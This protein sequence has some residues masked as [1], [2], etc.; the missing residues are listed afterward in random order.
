MLQVLPD[1]TNTTRVMLD[2]AVSIDRVRNYSFFTQPDSSSWRTID[3]SSSFSILRS[4][5]PLSILSSI[6]ES[7]R[8]SPARVAAPL[9]SDENFAEEVRLNLQQREV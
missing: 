1:S 5:L 8:E 9:S 6:V 2:K 3:S 4:F 7:F